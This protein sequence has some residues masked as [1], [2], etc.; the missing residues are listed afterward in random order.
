MGP[1]A[2]Q[3]QRTQLKDL[4][5]DRRAELHLSLRK[6][7]ARCI[8]PETG[9]QEIKYGWLHRLE[10]DE[11]TTPP[12]LPQLRALAAALNIPI[13]VVQEAAGAQYMGIEPAAGAIYSG[14]R[15]AR[16]TAAR[17]DELTDGDR[18]ELA[19]MVEIWARRKPSRANGEQQ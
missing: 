7:E 13:G 4:V 16:I 17:M 11:P 1:M 3:I 15:E 2:E 14:S 19:E 18:R 8:D 12:Q 10:N 9:N 6:L 5:R